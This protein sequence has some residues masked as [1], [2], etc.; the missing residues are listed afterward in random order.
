MPKVLLGPVI[1]E[2]KPQILSSCI[3]SLIPA[4]TQLQPL[5]ATVCFYS[6]SDQWKYFFSCLWLYHSILLLFYSLF[7][8]I[9]EGKGTFKCMNYR[10]ML[11]R[12]PPV[13]FQD[14][15]AISYPQNTAAKY[16]Q[17]FLLFPHHWFTPQQPVVNSQYFIEASLRKVTDDLCTPHANKCTPQPPPL[18]TSI[19]VDPCQS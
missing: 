2:L 19:V 9:F 13:S 18:L 4:G 1:Q 12:N 11:A 17:H 3:Q 16:T 10:L 15:I 6:Y 5:L 7:I 14:P 8:A